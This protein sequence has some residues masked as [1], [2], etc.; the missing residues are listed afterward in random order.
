MC[1]VLWVFVFVRTFHS[2]FMATNLLM[3]VCAVLWVFLFVWT[4]HSFLATNFYRK[5][6]QCCECLCLYRLSI[7]LFFGPKL[8][9]EMYSLLWLF[10]FVRTFHFFPAN[11]Y[12]KS[13]QCSSVCVC[14]AFSFSSFFDPT[15]ILEICKVLWMFAASAFLPSLFDPKPKKNSKRRPNIGWDGGDRLTRRRCSNLGV[16][17]QGVSVMRW[18]HHKTAVL[19]HPLL[20]W[21]RQRVTRFVF[22]TCTLGKPSQCEGFPLLAAAEFVSW[23]N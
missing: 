17:N 9:L 21:H 2:T 13:I 19:E 3:E 12:W 7:G 20:Q 15:P 5:C 11:L 23:L 18:C 1:T 8:L 22:R 4:F 16:D 6:V 14:M 10:V